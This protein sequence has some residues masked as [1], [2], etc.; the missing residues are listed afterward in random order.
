MQS[1][2]INATEVLIEKN[3][4]ARHL[5]L[6]INKAGMPLVTIPWWVSYRAGA[7]FARENLDWILENQAKHPTPRR[8][9]NG[10]SI[11]LLGRTLIISHQPQAR[12]GVWIEGEHLCV[13]GEADSLHRRVR[14]F[15]KQ[16]AYAFIQAKSLDLARQIDRRPT[17]IT[18]RDTS[19]RWG[20][21][22]AQGHLSFCW[23]LALA[24]DYVLEYIIAHEVAHL[25]EMNHGPA[26]WKITTTLTTHQADAHIW[27]KKNGSSLQAWE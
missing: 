7:Q 3:K 20:S 14:D 15:I 23:K 4:R 18:L 19:S 1:I 17:R 13:S 16:Q 9:E 21:C 25:K 2:K 10:L 8:F 5:K 26:F 27:L 22:S 12:R 11:Q 6:R 24:P